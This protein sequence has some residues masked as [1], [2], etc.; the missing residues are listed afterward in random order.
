MNIKIKNTLEY[1]CVDW[2]SFW[3]LDYSIKHVNSEFSVVEFTNKR[4]LKA[5][6]RIYKELD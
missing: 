4:D 5:F 2:L 1:A 6:W 3:D